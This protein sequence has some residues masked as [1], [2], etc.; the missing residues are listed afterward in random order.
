MGL[1]CRRCEGT[2]RLRH[3]I[4]WVSVFAFYVWLFL[5]S[6]P[7]V[8]EICHQ[9]DSHVKNEC[10]AYR[11]PAF[12]F[13]E[14]SKTFNDYGAAISAIATVFI[15]FFTFTLKRSTDRLWN[16]S[17]DQLAH[18]TISDERRSRAY[19]SIEHAVFWTAIGDGR[20]AIE[21]IRFRNFGRTPA[22]DLYV[23]VEIKISETPPEFGS[24][25]WEIGASMIGPG[26]GY[27]AE[28]K[29]GPFLSEDVGRVIDR[30]KHIYSR[31]AIKYID[32]F[33]AKRDTEFYHVNGQLFENSLIKWSA[34]ASRH[35]TRKN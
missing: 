19:V 28:I 27:V 9:G 2:L 16:A 20:F 35:P 11:I 14:T 33:G 17:D 26:S 8:T 25:E 32:E 24:N 13:I 21:E 22:Y 5:Y 1:S 31:I 30:S 12:I 7:V 3:K 10:A 34:I 29:R 4:L 6:I 23:S 15:A 18:L